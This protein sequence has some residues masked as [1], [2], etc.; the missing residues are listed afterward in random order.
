MG[1]DQYKLVGKYGRPT[2]TKS[3]HGVTHKA[4]EHRAKPHM[5][6]L[7]EYADRYE[8]DPLLVKAVIT[9]ESC[10]DT[11]AVS[12]V[13]AKGL[14]QLIDSTAQDYGVKDVFDP[15][16][17]IMA[18]SRYLRKLIDRFG[19]VQLGLAAYNAGP[20]NVKKYGGIPPFRETQ[21]YVRKVTA[22]QVDAKDE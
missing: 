13:G 22:F 9:V 5:A 4:L 8:L 19:D 12:R 21:A 1:G 16:E 2:A 20:G 11:H 15:T 14:M 17:N 7:E 18:G 6:V 3:C 10:F